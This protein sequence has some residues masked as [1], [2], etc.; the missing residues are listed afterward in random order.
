MQ[1]NDIKEYWPK[2]SISQ[3]RAIQVYHDAGWQIDPQEDD[4]MIPCRRPD[5][6][7]TIEHSLIRT[8]GRMIPWWPN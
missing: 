1:I 8:D 5:T 7:E 6:M 4:G 2:A 3:M